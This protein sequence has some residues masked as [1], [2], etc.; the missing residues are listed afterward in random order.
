[1]SDNTSQTGD[2]SGH[3]EPL[4]G[5]VSDSEYEFESETDMMPRDRNAL[6][7]LAGSVLANG[8]F[9]L[10]G[11]TSNSHE[12]SIDDEVSEMMAAEAGRG[13]DDDVLRDI[14]TNLVNARRQEAV[15]KKGYTDL[16]GGKVLYPSPLSALV[17]FIYHIGIWATVPPQHWQS[18][19]AIYTCMNNFRFTRNLLTSRFAC[20]WCWIISESRKGSGGD[21]DELFHTEG[22][23]M[24]SMNEDEIYD[25]NS[26]ERDWAMSSDANLASLL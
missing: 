8:D 2:G 20:R 24:H 16:G 25:D 17:H 23:E 22:V 11:N 5:L 26:G 7:K 19:N 12:K 18:C 3:F 21:D 9:T 14:L 4:S 1:M 10:D 6:T 13:I 15:K